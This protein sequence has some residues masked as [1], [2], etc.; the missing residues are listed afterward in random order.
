MMDAG[1]RGPI[2]W[3]RLPN[4]SLGRGGFRVAW[5]RESSYLAAMAYEFKLVHRIEFFETDRAGI[6]HFSNYFR[7]M[8]MAESAFFRSLGL[9]IA[10]GPSGPQVGWPR[11]HATCDY[12]APLHFEDEV[13]VHL[14]IAEKKSKAL[15]YQFKLRKLNAQS[16][17]EVAR[18][19]I[20]VVCVTKPP[21]GVM[22][23]THIPPEI[24]ALIEVAPAELL[25]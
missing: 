16:P 21:G 20:T 14:L 17:T 24:G 18:G 19:R 5:R 11:V 3:S 1:C 4:A 7:F 22:R 6:V 9:S 10:I 13:E 15:T 23:S 25:K 8:E 12:H 2:S